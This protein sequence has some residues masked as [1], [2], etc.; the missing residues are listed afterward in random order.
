M[1]ARTGRRRPWSHQTGAENA[2]TPKEDDE[3]ICFVPGSGLVFPNSWKVLGAA[4][5]QR[6]KILS[7]QKIRLAAER[8]LNNKKLK[9][10]QRFV[11]VQPDEPWT[12]RQF[13]RSGWV[14]KVAGQLPW[15]WQSDPAGHLYLLDGWRIRFG[16]VY[17]GAVPE[18][19]HSLRWHI[20]KFL[21]VPF[22]IYRHPRQKGLFPDS[23]LIQ[24]VPP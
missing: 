15:C 22:Q 8:V 1:V 11:P 18:K 4:R 17:Q 20:Y 10:R 5:G 3:E 24:Q 14:L 9:R 7:Q 21:H 23:P 2:E 6:S 19:V 12:C 13:V 16:W